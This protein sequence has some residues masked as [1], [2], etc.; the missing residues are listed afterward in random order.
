MID[1]F[2]NLA[3]FIE[4]GNL[5]VDGD[6]VQ[7][8]TGDR[9]SAVTLHSTNHASFWNIHNI[10]QH[11]HHKVVSLVP[12]EIKVTEKQFKNLGVFLENN[13]L[14]I[15]DVVKDLH[16]EVRR[17]GDED[18][19][20]IVWNKKNGDDGDRKILALSPRTET[21]HPRKKFEP[22]KVRIIQPGHTCINYREIFDQFPEYTF[23]CGESPAKHMVGGIMAQTTSKHSNQPLFI[24]VCEGQAYVLH[25][26]A[27]ERVEETEPVKRQGNPKYDVT[28]VGKY[29]SGSCVVDVYS[30]LDAF[31]VTIPQLQHSVK[32]E[33]KVGDRGHKDMRQDL[34]DIRDS[35]Q[36]A[37]DAFDAKAALEA[38][39]NES[40]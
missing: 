12:R 6:V 16:G 23:V 8:I 5:L 3:D 7:R 19:E 28:M 2:K 11:T 21:K 24:F 37:L 1:N 39:L 10:G 33:L 35:T 25:H 13:T 31:K 34:V 14:E 9:G 36:S 27:F 4:A 22:Y 38:K 32:K 40:I 26:G 20:L 29:G 18:T 30:V 17:I 15:G